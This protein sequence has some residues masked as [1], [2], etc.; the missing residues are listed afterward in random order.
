MGRGLGILFYFHSHVNKDKTGTCNS[1]YGVRVLT[2]KDDVLES[3]SLAGIYLETVEKYEQLS[4]TL[5]DYMLDKF[6][7]TTI[8]IFI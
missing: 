1:I 2:L 8:A 4:L 7:I 6:I 3:T 5:S